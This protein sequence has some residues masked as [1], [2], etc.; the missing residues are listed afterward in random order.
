MRITLDENIPTALVESLAA[1]QHKI[2]TVH[3]EGLQGKMDADIRTAAQREGAFLVTQDLGF[4]DTRRLQPG[5]H[6][7]ILLLRLKEPGREAL[8][9]HIQHL[10][11]TEQVESWQG[12]LVV[13]TE[14]KIRV[15]RP[16]T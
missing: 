5:T 15:V 3:S 1:L 14:R 13:A 2:D 4:S 12:C 7:G 11:E 6:Q 8:T 16:K 10:F 9:Q